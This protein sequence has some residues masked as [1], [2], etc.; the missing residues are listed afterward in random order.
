MFLA[1]VIS[2]DGVVEGSFAARSERIVQDGRTW[3]YILSHGDGGGNPEIRILQT[4]V[5]AIQLAKAA[6][7]AGIR[8]LMDKL[9]IDHIDRIRLAGAFG[10]FIDPK[11]VTTSIRLPS[12]SRIK[13]A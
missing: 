9:D 2:A 4:D 7:Y 10:S 3:S 6:L 5:R 12:G 11:N 1:G 8:L 13:A